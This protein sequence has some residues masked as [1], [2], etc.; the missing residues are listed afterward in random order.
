[1]HYAL[2]LTSLR[3]DQLDVTDE[4]GGETFRRFEPA[5]GQLWVGDRAYANPPGIDWVCSTGAEVLVRYNRGSLP[6]YDV[7]GN[8]LDVPHKLSRLG[9]PGRV[10]EWAAWVHP[11]GT[12]EAIGGRLC[13][14]R[15]PPDK[16]EEARQRLRKE[17][18]RK[19]SQESL[20][21]AE[22]VVVFTTA[23]RARLVKERILELYG[24]RWQVELHIKRDKSIARLDK[25][26][27]FR[28]DTIFSWLCAKLLLAQ[29]ARKVASAEVVFPRCACSAP[30]PAVTEASWRR[31]GTSP[32][33]AHH[34][35]AVASVHAGMA[36]AVLGS[37]SHSSLRHPHCIGAVSGASGPVQRRHARAS[38][39]VVQTAARQG[40]HLRPLFSRAPAAGAVRFGSRH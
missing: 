19:V 16:A 18:G 20:Q 15:L 8:P 14:V 38:C 7:K 12:E 39:C 26:P 17:Q 6:L 32:S 33:R 35:G 37:A 11:A 4:T 9:K 21:A 31:A 10:R 36:L 27:N 25:L 23:P 40:L 2:Q 5:A 29:L 13:A 22:F 28:P 1:M 34:R 3:P 24:L 30:A